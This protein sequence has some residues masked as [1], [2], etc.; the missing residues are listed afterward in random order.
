MFATKR[1]ISNQSRDLLK[2]LYNGVDSFN[3]SRLGIDHA[4]GQDVP[5]ITPNQ[6][7][8]NPGP[9]NPQFIAQFDIEIIQQFYTVNSGVY[10]LTT[11]AAV[12]AAQPSLNTKLAAFVFGQSDLQSGYPKM[13]SLFPVN[14]WNY[15]N[16]FVYGLGVQG[17]T[18]GTLDA[19]IKAQL[20]QGDIVLP[21]TA[22]LGGVNYL[23]IQIIRCANV[24]YGS[25]VAALNSD[26]FTTNMIRYVLDDVTAT[27]LAQ[28]RNNLRMVRQSLFG[29]A[30]DDKSSPN[31]FKIPEQQQPGIVDIPLQKLF[32][33]ESMLGLY[34]NVGISSVQWSVF[35]TEVI[36]V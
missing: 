2:N 29:K 23:G 7:R 36:K 11:A 19:T 15:D 35:V 10:T 32:D 6:T 20:Q 9:G 18:F 4:N 28:Y 3:K 24:G 13:R 30:N 1:R 34:I 16:P 26:N 8:L 22:V 5:M 33:K 12:V 21:F 25:L 31:S 27:G 14:V 17:T